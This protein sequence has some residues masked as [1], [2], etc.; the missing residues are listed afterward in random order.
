MIQCPAK[1]FDQVVVI[2]GFGEEI[3]RSATNGADGSGDAGIAGDDDRAGGG[4]MAAKG[5]E[6]REAVDGAACWRIESKPKE[7]KA[8]QYTS[9][10]VWIR[11]DN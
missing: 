8:S 1:A 7:S 2:E 11:K 3:D 4:L 9:S 5:A 10:R 6:E